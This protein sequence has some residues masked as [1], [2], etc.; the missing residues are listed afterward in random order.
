MF[1]F[2]FKA[3]VWRGKLAFLPEADFPQD[4]PNGKTSVS[5]AVDKTLWAA[6]VE[7]LKIPTGTE[8]QTL[9]FAL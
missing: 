4:R 6:C 3:F 8:V 1:L 9:I 2:L 7:V 5:S